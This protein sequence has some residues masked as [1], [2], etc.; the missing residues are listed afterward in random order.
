M[1]EVKFRTVIL[2]KNYFNDFYEKQTKKVKDKIVW[3][4]KLIET[5]Q[6]VPAEYLTHMDDTDSL[7]EIR[8]KQ[9]SN[10][11]R[12]FCFFDQGKIIVIINGFLKKTQKTPKSE[13]IKA[14]RIK[15]E[16]EN[17]EEY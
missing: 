4:F 1:V 13:I 16:Y 10:I 2:Y 15:K 9:G 12:V 14:L 5:T 7:Y 6:Q 11:Y 8:I 3:T 17:E